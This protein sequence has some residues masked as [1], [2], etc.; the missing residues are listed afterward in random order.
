MNNIEWHGLV[1]DGKYIEDDALPELNKI[2]ELIPECLHD[3]FDRMIEDFEDTL[4]KC[5]YKRGEV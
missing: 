3:R 5:V 2:K 4:S 1:L